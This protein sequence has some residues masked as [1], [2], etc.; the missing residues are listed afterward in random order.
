M[1]F[2]RRNTYF[3]C[4]FLETGLSLHWFVSDLHLGEGKQ[5]MYVGIQV[6]REWKASEPYFSFHLNTD[7]QCV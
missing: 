3:D 4:I 7:L 1:L 6:S 2:I 5:L